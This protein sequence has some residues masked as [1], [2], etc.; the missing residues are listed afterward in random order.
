MNSLD[1]TSSRSGPVGRTLAWGVSAVAW[2]AAAVV[3]GMVALA[4]AA[5]MVIMAVMATLLMLLT[6]ARRAPKTTRT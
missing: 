4:L 1:H 6:A 2:A 5:G 3:G